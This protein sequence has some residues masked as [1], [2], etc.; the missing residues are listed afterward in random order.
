MDIPSHRKTVLPIKGPVIRD[1]SEFM[2]VHLEL[3]YVNVSNPFQYFTGTRITGTPGTLLRV[4]S[5]YGNSWK[6]EHL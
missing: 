4:H 1:A 2:A 6:E 3:N 5:L